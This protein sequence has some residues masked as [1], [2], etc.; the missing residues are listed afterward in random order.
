MTQTLRMRIA[1]ANTDRR[2]NGAIQKPQPA[3][4]VLEVPAAHGT[5]D[6]KGPI[7]RLQAQ[8]PAHARAGFLLFR[9]RISVIGRLILQAVRQNVLEHL[10][11]KVTAPLRPMRQRTIPSYELENLTIEPRSQENRR[12]VI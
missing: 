12:C 7:N 5:K 8:N 6:C 9:G 11:A 1:P 2:W 4:F 10:A 3:H